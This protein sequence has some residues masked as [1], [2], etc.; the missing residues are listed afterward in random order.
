MY[1]HKLQSFEKNF[2]FS[3]LVGVL[4]F[5]VHRPSGL[6]ARDS[7][8]VTRDM[9]PLL[10]EHAEAEAIIAVMPGLLAVGRIFEP[11]FDEVDGTFQVQRVRQRLS[12][13]FGTPQQ[14]QCLLTIRRRHQVGMV[15][16]GR[17]AAVGDLL[18]QGYRPVVGSLTACRIRPN[19]SECHG[20]GFLTLRN[21]IQCAIIH[22]A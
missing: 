16:G 15:H 5:A 2:R 19:Q 21:Y 11:A 17:V 6:D 22:D 20:E 7:I 18:R 4:L 9:A 13:A 14:N 1:R 8:L 12:F 10:G 3:P